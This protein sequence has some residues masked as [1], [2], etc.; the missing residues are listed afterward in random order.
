MNVEEELFLG[1]DIGGTNVKMGLVDTS[2]SITH[3]NKIP[4]LSL[5]KSGDFMG[6][7]LATIGDKLSQHEQ[8]NKIGIGVPGMLNKSR[9]I[10]LE[11]PAIPELNN[12]NLLA[13]LKQEF[14]DKKFKLENDANAAALGEFYFAKKGFIMPD[15]FI[16][17][18]MGTGIGGAAIIDRQI[19]V[20]GNGNGMEIGHIVSRNGKTLEE[21]IG[22]KG[23]ISLAHSFIQEYEG[24]SILSGMVLS[25]SEIVNAAKKNDYLAKAILEKVGEMLGEALVTAIRIL[26]IKEVIVGGGLSASFNLIIEPLMEVLHSYLTPY[27]TSQ[28]HIRRASLANNAG[29]IGAASLCFIDSEPLGQ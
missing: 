13:A 14:P 24:K 19:F 10:T 7:L 1:I 28:I 17:I 12:V 15:D 5:R 2:G 16:F 6:A 18:T 27:Y 3:S 25:T 21:N 4:T 11:L 8:V 29:I 26:D 20:G 23:I 22:K 9:D